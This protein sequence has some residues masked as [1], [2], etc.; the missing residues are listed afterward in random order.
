MALWGG[1]WAITVVLEVVRTEEGGPETQTVQHLG[2]PLAYR[3]RRG[4]LYL[5]KQ[6]PKP[7]DPVYYKFWARASGYV[8]L[9]MMYWW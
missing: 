5:M 2:S 7:V 1:R 4:K 8:Y 3:S 9:R 6:D